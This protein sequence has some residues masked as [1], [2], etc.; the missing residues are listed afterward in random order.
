MFKKRAISPIY[1][2][3]YRIGEKTTKY[4]IRINGKARRIGANEAKI[5][6]ALTGSKQLTMEEIAD[7]LWPAL[8]PYWWLNQIWVHVFNLRRA[9]LGSKWQIK[10]GRKIFLNKQE[11]G[12]RDFTTK[13]IISLVEREKQ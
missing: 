2:R 12:F 5:L 6:L 8:R 1:L 11:K 4:E 7:I 3:W 9:I 10:T 13:A